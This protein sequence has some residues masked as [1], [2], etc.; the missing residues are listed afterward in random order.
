MCFDRD[1]H[2]QYWRRYKQRAGRGD[3][4]ETMS[5]LG[6]CWMMKRERYWEL[7]VLDELHGSWGQMGTEVA[8]KSW[9]SGGKLLCNRT[10]WFAHQF[11]TQK[12][13]GFPYPLSG[14]QVRQ[15]R[16]HSRWLWWENNWEKQVYPL[17]WLIEKFWPIPGWDEEDLARVTAAG[18]VF[19]AANPLAEKAD[20]FDVPILT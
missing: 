13:F 9:L 4:V 17:S 7:D 15:A 8:C 11:R 5:L 18:A 14:K 19:S 10:T 12:G 16:A 2:F 3:M 6:A 1:L 20:S